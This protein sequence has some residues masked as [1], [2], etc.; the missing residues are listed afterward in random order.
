MKKIILLL[1]ALVLIVSCTKQA[2]YEIP[3]DAN[4]KVILTTISSTTTAGISSLDAGFSVTATLPN[5]KSGDVMKVELLQLQTVSGQATK[6]L[7]PMAGTQKDVTVGSDLK[8]TV[9]YTRAEALLTKVTDYVTVVYNGATDYAKV[10]VEMVPA[11][12]VSKPTASGKEVDIARTAEV[13]Y[14]IV[15]VQPKEAA[16]TGDLVAKMKNG[17]NEPWV[18]MT[19]SPFSG[20][21]PFLVP[22]SGADFAVGMDTMY[23]SFTAAK[24]S[25]TEE[26]TTSVIVRDPF[27]YLKKAATLTLGGSSA[28]RNLLI[29]A[30]VA[31]TD[32]TANI[33]VLGTLMLK[34]GSA[35]LAAGKTIQFVPT[36]LAMYTKN[37]SNDA[38]AAFN[39]GVPV[40]TV[41]P[42]A[43]AGIFVFKIVNGVNPADVFY[44]MLKVTSVVPGISVSFEYRIGDQYA[45]LLVIQ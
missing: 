31:E 17:K 9:T 45:H 37:N 23:F 22:I 43:G 41:D 1:C 11:T 14:F 38:I 34:G 16:Y 29:N 2:Y 35:W 42:G 6:Q 39:A 24:G 25:F 13:A 40:A 26:I 19:G 7:L 33:A 32:A 18:T 27:F 3:L 28:G 12:T 5:A 44:G 30:A 36:D 8:A 4:G 10:R 20:A 15:R 21:Q